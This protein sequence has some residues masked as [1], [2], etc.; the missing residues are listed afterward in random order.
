MILQN[1]ILSEIEIKKRIVFE[2]FTKTDFL[3]KF[4]I[5]V[6]GQFKKIYFLIDVFRCAINDKKSSK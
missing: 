2:L 4:T 1:F 5:I 6:S 3:R